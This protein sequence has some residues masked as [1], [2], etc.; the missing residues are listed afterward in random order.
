MDSRSAN[1]LSNESSATSSPVT[2]GYYGTNVSS[3]ALFSAKN[4]SSDL[5]FGWLGDDDQS[6]NSSQSSDSY[7]FSA[8]WFAFDDLNDFINRVNYSSVGNLSYYDAGLNSSRGNFSCDVNGTIDGG[9][10]SDYC[11]SGGGGQSDE[12]KNWWALILII[13]PCLTIFGNVLVIL[14][15][16]RERT[17]QTVTNYFIVSLA[18]AD[19]LVAM[20][21][22]PFAVYVLVSPSPLLSL[23]SFFRKIMVQ[24]VHEN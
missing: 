13:V 6:A 11:D 5:E 10:Y 16:K 17:L 7:A 21:V 4:D 14:A 2:D 20:V 19:L 8:S 18:I 22:M 24:S 3:D 15:V 1:V 9:N 23:L 12:A